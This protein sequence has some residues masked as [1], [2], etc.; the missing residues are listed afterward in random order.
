MRALARARVLTTA[1]LTRAAAKL[2]TTVLL[3]WA[4]GARAQAPVMP[5]PTLSKC[6]SET[7]PQL[8]RKWRATFLMAPF[9]NTQLVLGDIAYDGTLKAMRA[10]LHGLKRGTLDLLV[11]G[12][13]TYALTSRGSN[14]VGCEHLGDTG[15]RPLPQSWLTVASQCAGSAPLAETSVDW[16][17][18]PIEPK[19][20][21]YWIWYKTT[22]QTPFRLVFPFPDDRL[23]VLG[24]FALSY[25]VS[26]E[27][28]GNVDLSQATNACKLA[29]AAR[30]GAAN[31]SPRERIDAMLLAADKASDEIKRLLPQLSACP[32]ASLPH[33]PDRVA[34][35]GFMTPFDFNEEPYQTEVL[36]DWTI[37]AQ[38]SRIYFPQSSSSSV[39]DALMLESGGYNVTFYREHAAT[40]RGAL[41]GLIRPDWAERAP[42]SCE[43]MIDGNTPL[44]P[45]GPTRVISCPLASPRAA[46][47][48]YTRDDRPMTFAV[49]SLRGDEG[50][51]LFAV[52]DYRNWVPAPTGLQRSA[53]DR[54]AHCG[55]PQSAASMQGQADPARKQ[56][57]TCHM[58]T[59]PR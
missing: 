32:S 5:L 16:W 43:A 48:W 54:P 21:S 39:Q 35:T 37:P 20:S 23:A 3:V 14:I 24:E 10:R 51:G 52:L 12:N 1:M 47:A 45:Y 44:S 50:S 41:P 59:D 36:Y 26:F 58:G 4:T 8:P 38:R 13:D 53:F 57:A 56:C 6:Q 19:P 22:D 15:W 2:L 9:S 28:A 31:Q 17:K 27:K 29:P 46:W 11:Q 33:W 30:P 18:T 7:L 40:C 25:Q 42:C 34:L 55:P 49:T